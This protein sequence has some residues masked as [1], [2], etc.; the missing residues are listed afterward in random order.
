MTAKKSIRLET[1]QKA[2]I[3]LDT[4]PFYAEMGGQVG[5]TGEIVG[6]KGKFTVTNTV[7]LTP[8]II[9]APRQQS[10]KAL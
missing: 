1:G 3:I 6:A 4:T 9:A 7:R 8:E 5:D 2:G 10:L